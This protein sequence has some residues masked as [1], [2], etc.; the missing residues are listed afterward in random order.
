VCQRIQSGKFARDWMLENKVKPD[1]VQGDPRQARTATRS[2]V[3]VNSGYDAVIKK[4]A[5]S[6]RQELGHCS[7]MLRSAP[8][9]RLVRC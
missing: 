2:E 1:L 4:G 8:H 5:L 9:L 6:T 3:G 7:W